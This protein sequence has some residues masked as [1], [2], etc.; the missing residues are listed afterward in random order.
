MLRQADDRFNFGEADLKNLF[1]MAIR[2]LSFEEL[3][4]D[5]ESDEKKLLIKSNA[6]GTIPSISPQHDCLLENNRGDSHYS[7]MEPEN[8]LTPFSPIGYYRATSLLEV[9][10]ANPTDLAST[11]KIVRTSSDNFFSGY[12]AI[13]NYI[14]FLSPSQRLEAYRKILYP[15]RIDP[16]IHMKTATLKCQKNNKKPRR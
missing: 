3:E 13:A 4:S 2:G 11:H 6:V 14:K 16:L 10:G 7:F 8:S 12:C 9:A 15:T 5:N 1:K